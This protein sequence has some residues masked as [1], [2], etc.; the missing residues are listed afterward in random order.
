MRMMLF[1]A[2][3]MCGLT[4]AT[5]ASARAVAPEHYLTA[6]QNAVQANATDAALADLDRADAV[7]RA[8]HAS[9]VALGELSMARTALA[10][11]DWLQ[12]EDYMGEAMQHR[13]VSVAGG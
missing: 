6:A 13:G 4:V 3:G 11:G 5:A 12:A 10:R 7:A 8:R 1:V 9:R 2:A